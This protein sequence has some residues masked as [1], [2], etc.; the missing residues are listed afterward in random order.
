MRN[1]EP[2]PIK[3]AGSPKPLLLSHARRQIA[4]NRMFLHSPD[5]IANYRTRMIIRIHEKLYS[6]INWI[7]KESFS[8]YVNW[9]HWAANLLYNGDRLL[10]YNESIMIPSQDLRDHLGKRGL[11]EVFEGYFKIIDQFYTRI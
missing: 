10:S 11:F 7:R 9:F 8:D 3:S 1:P 5:P 2:I 6:R 4:M